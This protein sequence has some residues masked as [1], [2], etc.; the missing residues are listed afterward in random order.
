MQL[1]V[2]DLKRGRVGSALN[3][4]VTAAG[5]ISMVI[6]SVSGEVIELRWIYVMAGLIVGSGGLVGLLVLQEPELELDETGM[7]AI[8]TQEVLAD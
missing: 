3:A 8:E 6:A 7:E 5:L 4:V 2:P 1:A